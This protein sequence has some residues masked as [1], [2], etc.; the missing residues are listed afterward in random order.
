MQKYTTVIG[1][2][3]VDY[4][5][6]TNTKFWNSMNDT[7]KALVQKG[8][9]EG[10][11]VAREEATKLNEESLKKLKERGNT[12]INELSAD[13]IDAFRKAL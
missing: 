1:E 7:T 13:Q 6:L 5:L 9:D 3:R 12:K 2:T 4:A 11:K 8:A 10:T